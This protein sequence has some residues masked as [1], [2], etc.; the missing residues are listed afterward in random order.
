M[1]GLNI[2]MRNSWRLQFSAFLLSLL[3]IV[4]VPPSP[5]RSR[6][7]LLSHLFRLSLFLLVDLSL[8]PPLTRTG[9]PSFSEIF[10]LFGWSFSLLSR[11]LVLRCWLRRFFIVSALLDLESSTYDSKF[12]VSAL[13]VLGSSIGDSKSGSKPS[14][15]RP[16]MVISVCCKA[17]SPSCPSTGTD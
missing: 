5:L 1:L 4:N 6:F 17:Y 13:L 16:F 8:N 3:F 9:R 12:L 10:L 2:S 14:P 7:L 15:L 11:S